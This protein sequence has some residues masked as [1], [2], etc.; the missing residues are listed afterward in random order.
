MTDL[1]GSARGK[2]ARL[3]DIRIAAA[4][5]EHLGLYR[6]SPP[7]RPRLLI[8]GKVYSMSEVARRERRAKLSG[9]W[10]QEDSSSTMPPPG[11][12]QIR[13]AQTN[14]KTWDTAFHIPGWEGQMDYSPDYYPHKLLFQDDTKFLTTPS[15]PKELRNAERL[16]YYIS[17]YL[18]RAHDNGQFVSNDAG[19]LVSRSSAQ[20]FTN[21]N[22]FYKCC[23]VAIELWER[24]YWPQGTALLSQA[25]ELVDVILNERD[26]KLL[27]VLCDL[28]ILLPT[29]GWGKLYDILQQR[30]CRIVEIEAKK[31]HEQ[32]YPWAQMFACISRLSSTEVAATLQQ[33][34]KCGFDQMERLLP[35][36]PWD[37]LN[38]SCYSNHQLR[39]GDNVQDHWDALLAQST[40]LQPSDA[41]DTQ[42]Q[43]ARGKI[44]HLRGDH[45]EALSI[46]EHI[47]SQCD[48]ARQQ[49]DMKWMPMEIEAL[50]VSARCHFALHK[51]A[52]NT[53]DMSAAEDLLDK[54]VAK[55]TRLYGP[56]S[57]TTI[58][59]QHTLW[60]WLREQD[61]NRE[62]DLLRN[63]IDDAVGRIE[64]LELS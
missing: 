25:L 20:S 34:W 51:L 33:S 29:K 62:A 11:H 32:Q 15:D 16:C 48:H 54:A 41:S 61:R 5:I 57:A 21:L 3:E 7:S 12:I 35:E 31:K 10:F 37:A 2:Y 39:I 44:F 38:I 42:R 30:L 52:P 1:Q 4:M 6:L 22:N 23:I 27:D 64:A 63:T 18:K 60:L 8:N 56:K 46:M 45:Q 36:D 14:H 17:N 47:L 28:C 53:E 58:A 24:G 9:T 43:F 55:S 59:L 40:R 50:E 19:E 26:P 13:Q 49:D